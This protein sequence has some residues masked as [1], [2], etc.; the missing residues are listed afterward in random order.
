MSLQLEALWDDCFTDADIRK[1]LA[2]LPKDL[3]ETYARCLTK[4][5]VQ[6]SRFAPKILRWVCAAVEPFKID[7]LR[8]ALAIDPKTGCLCRDELPSAQEVL[9]CCSNLIT[10]NNND[11]V[12]LAH[13]SVRQF[14]ESQ[15]ADAQLLSNGFERNT[16]ELE[17][18]QLCVTHLTSSD[19]SLALQPSNAGRGSTMQFSSTAVEIITEPVQSW[20]RPFFPK[21]RPVQISLPPRISRA[22]HATEVPSFFSLAKEQWAFL[23]H[24]IDKGS[25][26]WPNFRTLALEPNFSWRW[27]PWE[28]IGQSL[29][30]HYCGLLGWA[31]AKQHLPLLH[32]LLTSQEVRANMEIFNLPLYHHGNLPVLHLASRTGNIRAVELLLPLCDP[33][34]TDNNR[35]TAL[36]HAADIGCTDTAVQLVKR[37]VSKDVKDENGDTALEIAARNGHQ[38]VVRFLVELGVHT[39][40]KRKER[41]MS[42]VL[43]LAAMNGHDDTVRVLADLGADIRGKDDNGWTVLHQ[44]AMNDHYSTIRALIKLGADVDVK[45]GNEWAALHWAASNGH[46]NTVRA[47]IELGADIKV[48]S[49]DGWTALQLGVSWVLAGLGAHNGAKDGNE[50]TALHWA[51]SNGHYDTTRFLAELGADIEAKDSNGQTA[52]RW[53]ASSRHHDITRF[54]VELGADVEAKDSNGQTALHWAA[55][56]RH[57]DITRFLVELGADVE[58]KDS[59]GQTAL[60]WAASNGHHDTVRILVELGAEVGAG[61]DDRWTALHWAARNGHETTVRT[62]TKLGADVNKE[63]D[64]KADDSKREMPLCLKSP[65]KFLTQEGGVKLRFTPLWLATEN[66][67]PEVFQHLVEAGAN[68]E[69][70]TLEG[71]SGG[72]CAVAFSPDGR[73]IASG[74]A[75]STVELWDTAMGLKAELK[76]HSGPVC[77][78]AFSPDGK[79]VASASN[80]M[81]VLLWDAA[82]ATVQATLRGHSGWVL[83]ITFSPD[84]KLVA[85]ASRDRTVVLWDTATATV[86]ATLKGHSDLVWSVAFSPDGKLVASASDDGT[87]IFWDTATATVQATLKGHSGFARGIAFSPDGKLVA[88]AS[89]GNTIVLLNTATTTVQVTL[90]GH[91]G[92]VWGVAFSPDGKLVASASDNMTV[93]LWDTAT[94]TVQAT[95][96]GHSRRVWSVAFSPNGKLVASASYDGTVKL[97]LVGPR[98]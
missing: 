90:K 28:P 2:N 85:S 18:G 77:G 11:Q 17:L 92:R 62:L 53:A 27:H 73:L 13:H 3:G 25:D 15:P 74:S 5:G 59:N 14:L 39:N 67:H 82:T 20:M 34:K 80:D 6:Q 45:D 76:G 87:V 56:R 37:R 65:N 49:S 10:Q 54:L 93:V 43:S 30:S 46:R 21:P 84:S 4:K 24:S 36:H 31:T 79:L 88:L 51:I 35:R 33:K 19:Y 89:Y 72:I 16:A 64:F 47:L 86:Q 91:S 23:T 26:C 94:A 29:Q 69:V 52:L 55:S 58:A 95:L 97:W 7:Q 22:P 61:D 50:R 42:K 40:A 78:V 9:K 12:L 63:A 60:H 83:G 1:A 81:T 70:I 68:R 32:A 38:D 96:K 44:A 71:C 48:K 41:I 66:D 75:G 98:S 57:H 8:E